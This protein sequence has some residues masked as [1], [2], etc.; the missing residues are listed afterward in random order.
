MNIGKTN[1]AI[2]IIWTEKQLHFIIIKMSYFK[3]QYLAKI[4]QRKNKQDVLFSYVIIYMIHGKTVEI[5]KVIDSLHTESS[6]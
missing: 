6:P 2:G 1:Y 5:S 4:L 3:S